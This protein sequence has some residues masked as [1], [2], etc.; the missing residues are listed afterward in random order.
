MIIIRIIK[1]NTIPIGPRP[2]GSVNPTYSI[3]LEAVEEISVPLTFN[4]VNYLA[5]IGLR[6]RSK[7]QTL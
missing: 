7:L 3:K 1:R 2:D 6:P 4:S 5:V